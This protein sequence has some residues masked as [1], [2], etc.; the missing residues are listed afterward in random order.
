MPSKVAYYLEQV[1][2]AFFAE[3]FLTVRLA[4]MNVL[5]VRT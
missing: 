3:N 1:A 4:T 5:G 2:L